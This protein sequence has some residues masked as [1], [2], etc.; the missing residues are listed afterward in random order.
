LHNALN[1]KPMSK[2]P[3]TLLFGLMVTPIPFPIIL[4]QI[5][6]GLDGWSLTGNSN[7]SA[8]HFI[9][10]TDNS[11]LAFRTN[12][13]ERA[14]FTEAGRLAIGSGAV[15]ELLRVAGAI[16]IEDTVGTTAGTIRWNGSDLEGLLYF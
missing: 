1:I 6:T 12:D 15:D 7:I 4:Q 3:V 16:K 9:R 10:A 14:R 2:L 8:T 13:I 11:A 5:A